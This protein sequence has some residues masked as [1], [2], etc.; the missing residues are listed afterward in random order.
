MLKAVS[1]PQIAFFSCDYIRI[2]VSEL[3]IKTGLID[4]ILDTEKKKL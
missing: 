1:V 4:V 2:S 3:I